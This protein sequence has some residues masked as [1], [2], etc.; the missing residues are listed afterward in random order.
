MRL[1]FNMTIH[2]DHDVHKEWKSWMIN[3]HIP[4][5]MNTQCFESWKM[6]RVLGADE[7]QGINYAIQ[8]V[9]PSKD[10]FEEF[11]DLHMGKLQK[12]QQQK[13]RGKYAIFNTLL[14]MV[15]EGRIEFKSN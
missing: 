8:F 3:D 15:N 12:L 6:S 1:L 7:T 13:F 14:E 10:K 2:I 5:I 4:I 11:R 9:S